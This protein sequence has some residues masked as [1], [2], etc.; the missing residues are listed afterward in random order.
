M[1]ICANAC[2][3][4][5]ECSEP[6]LDQKRRAA[7]VQRGVLE[8]DGCTKDGHDAIACTVLNHPSLLAHRVIGQVL[9]HKKLALAQYS[10]D[11]SSHWH[12]GI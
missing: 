10:A 7:R 12:A 5:A 6:L 8:S 3:I 2:E 4:A 1:G 11:S 9:L